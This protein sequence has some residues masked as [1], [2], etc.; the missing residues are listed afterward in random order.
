[1]ILD[2]AQN[3]EKHF[4]HGWFVVRNRTLS[5]AQEGLEPLER[6][7]REKSFFG[8]EPWNKL[9]ESRRGT[10]PLKKYLA[11]LLCRRIQE[12]FPN[13]LS[14]IQAGQNSVKSELR[15]LAAPRETVEKKRTYLTT[16]AQHFHF[17]ASQAL[18]GRYEM[19]STSD[20][21]LRMKVREFNNG[22]VLDM[23]THGHSTP[24]MEVQKIKYGFETDSNTGFDIPSDNSSSVPDRKLNSRTPTKPQPF[25]AGNSCGLFGVGLLGRG[26]LGGGPFG[27]FGS[28]PVGPEDIPSST[29]PFKPY[30]CR[31]GNRRAIFVSNPYWCWDGSCRAI[32]YS[33][34]ALQHY[35]KFSSEELR[36]S[37]YFQAQ[38][39]MPTVS[40]S[41]PKSTKNIF[42]ASP[43][44]D[45]AFKVS[46][47]GSESLFGNS[48]SAFGSTHTPTRNS[49]VHAA[50]I[51]PPFNSD[52]GKSQIYQWIR[53]ELKAGRGTE[54][55]GTLNPDI[56]PVLFR[57]QAGNWRAKSQAHFQKVQNMTMDVTEK[58]IE[59]TCADKH[60]RAQIRTVV[61]QANKQA[62][63]RMLNQ[64]SER[65]N[66]IL[67]KHLQTNNQAFEEKIS[68]ARLLRF[69]GAL[70]R[71]RS[72]RKSQSQPA[73]STSPNHGVS[74][75]QLII[76]MRDTAALFAELHMSNFQ[77][78]EEEIHDTLKSY[79]EIALNDFIEY[80]T[81][82][83]VERY[84][85]DPRGPLLIFSPIYIGELSD[86]AV[87]SLAAED[88]AT[89]QR[90][91]EYEESLARL[92]RAEEIAMKYM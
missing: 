68:E 10:Q 22:F 49:E 59:A 60:T 36:L 74:D 79:Y 52:R 92:N 84:L 4:D 41:A 43:S 55:Q 30:W 23:K 48:G 77:N 37:D 72:S 88:E 40:S 15:S 82:Q 58:P 25:G 7:M 89:V 28:Q 13:I 90:R 42:G 64:L 54:L 31:E 24:F 46:P 38:S 45:G 17:L 29:P 34:S 21:R 16:I 91:A 61:H 83:I 3:K 47:K 2:L 5:E 35:Q 32:F 80:V 71:F 56:L 20:M 12:I 53:N 14:T 81:Q 6:H 86:Q 19:I 9:Q 73:L 66:D 8:N 69:Q 51:C 27:G 26:S 76:D 18:H 87:E 1:M 85:N 63:S 70:E 67:T 44:I 11:T 57:R 50:T 39:N 78:L 65:L 33:I 75:T 62:T